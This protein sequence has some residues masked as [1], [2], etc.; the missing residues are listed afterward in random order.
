MLVCEVAV[1]EVACEVAREVAIC[2]YKPTVRMVSQI[3]LSDQTNIDLLLRSQP[4]EFTS[5]TVKNPSVEVTYLNR[6]TSGCP[7]LESLKI[8]VFRQ[9]HQPGSHRIAASVTV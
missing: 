7:A 8:K 6:R 9:K 1:C 5:L 3:I 2:L 4:G